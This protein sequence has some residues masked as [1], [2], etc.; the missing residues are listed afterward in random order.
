VKSQQPGSYETAHIFEPEITLYETGCTQQDFDLSE[1]EDDVVNE[2]SLEAQPVKR[3]ALQIIELLHKTRNPIVQSHNEALSPSIAA[4]SDYFTNCAESSVSQMSGQCP[5]IKRTDLQASVLTTKVTESG[6]VSLGLNVESVFE[7]STKFS[8]GF[9][10]FKPKVVMSHSGCPGSAVSNPQ[11][12]VTDL[13]VINSGEECFDLT[14]SPCFEQTYDDEDDRVVKLR[15]VEKASEVGVAASTESVVSNRQ[16]AVGLLDVFEDGRPSNKGFIQGDASWD[17]TTACNHGT[18]KTALD[19]AA[20]NEDGASRSQ[21]NGKDN[22][23]YVPLQCAVQMQN[24]P[25]CRDVCEM[26]INQNF[27]KAECFDLQFLL[28]SPSP[29]SS[30]VP[31]HSNHNSLYVDDVSA[32]TNQNIVSDAND[33]IVPTSNVNISE[34]LSCS[35][36]SSDNAN[37]A[38]DPDCLTLNEAP[39]DLDAETSGKSCAFRK[40]TFCVEQLAGGDELIHVGTNSQSQDGTLN[41]A[42]RHARSALDIPGVSPVQP[43]FSN[44]EQSQRLGSS[45]KF[46]QEMSVTTAL[47]HSQL[48]QL[49]PGKQSTLDLPTED[50]TFNT[51]D[52]L[53]FEHQK[54]LVVTDT[55]NLKECASTAPVI[56][57]LPEWNLVDMQS[58]G[59]KSDAVLNSYRTLNDEAMS[60]H[61]WLDSLQFSPDNNIHVL[62]VENSFAYNVERVADRSPR[63]SQGNISFQDSPAVAVVKEGELLSSSHSN[64]TDQKDDSCLPGSK[65]MMEQSAMKESFL[66]Q[67]IMHQSSDFVKRKFAEYDDDDDGGSCNTP[68]DCDIENIQNVHH[69]H[70]LPDDKCLELGSTNKFI[71]N[72]KSSDVKSSTEDEYR[73]FLVPHAKDLNDTA[74]TEVMTDCKQDFDNMS[75]VSCADDSLQ[76][77]SSIHVCPSMSSVSLDDVESVGMLE[78]SFNV[79]DEYDLLAEGSSSPFRVS[80]TNIGRQEACGLSGYSSAGFKSRL[81]QQLGSKLMKRLYC[82]NV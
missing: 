32:S 13:P 25:I 8:S 40:D 7:P 1:K 72:K 9:N 59:K 80:N 20:I 58:N 36:E 19:I 2:L 48:N 37:S 78:S 60:K 54:Q 77:T 22:S 63:C 16:T 45:D 73:T 56:C 38:V 51:I 49:Y 26:R 21:H 17:S 82:K 81:S 74:L 10:N 79:E 33:M 52:G 64:L 55:S 50:E 43:D 70:Q 18:I 68:E 39:E 76:R 31:A 57:H 61:D 41:G 5:R 29:V 4:M 69:D 3:N 44:C 35:V 11:T 6:V 34:N 75:P 71:L 47:K 62:C 14:L 42:D 46:S 23:D 12:G 24:D 67:Q 66:S 65:L 53:Q 15:D 27:D 30:P 28:D